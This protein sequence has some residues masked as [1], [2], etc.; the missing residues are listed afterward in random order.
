MTKRRVRTI[1]SFRSGYGAP[2]H[3]KTLYGKAITI[4]KIGFDQTT[5]LKLAK[6]ATSRFGFALALMTLM[7]L[8]GAGRQCLPPCYV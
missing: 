1:Q 4:F 5:I 6:A 3:Q 2:M 7:T 8:N